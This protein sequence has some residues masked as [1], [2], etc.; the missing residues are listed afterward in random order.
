MPFPPECNTPNKEAVRPIVWRRAS[1]LIKFYGAHAPVQLLPGQ[2]DLE[3]RMARLFL[4]DPRIFAYDKDPVA[5]RVAREAGVEEAACRDVCNIPP[6]QWFLFS[7]LD[8]CNVM[9][10]DLLRR[11]RTVAARSTHVL[12]VSLSL[13]RWK[14]PVGVPRT[15]VPA[16]AAIWNKTNAEKNRC[17]CVE[18]LAGALPDWHFHIALG[19]R[20]HH[21][22]ILTTLW[23]STPATS[24]LVD[25]IRV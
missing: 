6:G 16:V 14:L 2:T 20:G 12:G 19:Y 24:T 22:P 25:W 5:V 7:N 3:I 13:G 1:N 21:S 15:S 11:V 17:L 4:R 9:S 8:F 18:M 23:A 10:R